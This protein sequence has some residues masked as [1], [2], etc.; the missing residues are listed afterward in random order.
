MDSSRVDTWIGCRSLFE[1]CIEM[2][3]DEVDREL[4]CGENILDSF[5]KILSVNRLRLVRSPFISPTTS[6]FNENTILL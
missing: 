6:P 3:L 1:M 2:L 5:Q 4:R